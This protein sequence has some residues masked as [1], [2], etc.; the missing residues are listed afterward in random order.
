MAFDND[1]GR[2]MMASAQVEARGGSAAFERD[3]GYTVRSP[4]RFEILIPG[5]VAAPKILPV[6]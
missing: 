2:L 4:G 1:L 5:G 3:D 6:L